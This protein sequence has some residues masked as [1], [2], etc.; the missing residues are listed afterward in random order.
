MLTGAHVLIM[1]SNATADAAF[2]RDVLGL[3]HVDA[4]EGFLIFGLPPSEVAM[5]EAD[6]AGKGK[7][8]LYLI[9]D[10]IH[11]FVDKMTAKAVACDPV[12]ERGWGSVSAIALPSGIKLG[13]YESHHD[14]PVA[15]KKA[16]RALRET[17]RAVRKATKKAKRVAKKAAKKR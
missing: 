11:R 4:G 17:A 16:A 14:R 9:A 12:A 15:K 3:P 2:L 10:D 6:E 7:H 1:S 13:V 8:E 5:H